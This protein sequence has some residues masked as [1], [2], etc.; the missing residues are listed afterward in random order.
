MSVLAAEREAPGSRSPSDPAAALHSCSGDEQPFP[1]ARGCSPR[2]QGKQ[3]QR[4]GSFPDSFRSSILNKFSPSQRSTQCLMQIHSNRCHVEEMTLCKN[5]NH[6]PPLTAR[7]GL[8]RNKE[9]NSQRLCEQCLMLG[10]GNHR[11]D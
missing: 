10:C 3:E 1:C 4:P 11:P 2:A 6:P 9:Q 8:K 5:R 7:E